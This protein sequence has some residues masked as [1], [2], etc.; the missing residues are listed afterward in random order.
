VIERDIVEQKIKE[1][2]IK[3]FVAGK[4]R[5]SGHSNTV[6]Q[7]TPLGEKII[8]YASRPGLVVGRQGQ[9][10]RDLTTALKSTFGLENP[11][12]EVGEVENIYLDA[13]IVAEMIALSLE[14]F[15]PQRFKA[16]MHRTMDNVIKAGALGVEIIL[17]GKLPSARARSWRVYAGYLKKC[18]EISISGVKKAG[19]VAGLKSG[20]IGVK[21]SIMPPDIKLPDKITVLSSEL[22]KEEE[23]FDEPEQKEEE[24]KAA[25]K[26]KKKAK[27]KPKESKKPKAE[28]KTKKVRKIKE[29]KDEQDNEGAKGD[30]S[31]STKGKDK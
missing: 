27:T 7:R 11:Q 2:Q 22:I 23:E 31:S 28:K 18:G 13:N 1:F 25:K 8:V 30:E 15:G 14:R 20:V 19:A 26:T 9:N 16:V 6:V 12:I 17:S 5:R 4:V 24:T 10:I 29:D 21:V 3:E